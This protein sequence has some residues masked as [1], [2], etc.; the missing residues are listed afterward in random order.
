M[1]K[2]SKNTKDTEKIAKFF[3]KT[4]K[5][6]KR[7]ATL[8]G[9]YG[10]L[11]VGKT[12]FVQAVAKQLKLKKKVKS[13][14]FVIIKNYKLKTKNYKLLFHIDAYRLKDEKELAHLGWKEILTDPEH[15]VFIEW[16]EQV[17]KILP[18][19]HQKIFI[20]HLNVGNKSSKK[21][22]RKFEIKKA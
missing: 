8:I 20:S 5:P 22:H 12:T 9:L 17:I 4:L 10:D 18:K 1:Q 19:K 2:I 3:L 11:G 13:P 21:E 14:T 16:P 6:K 15:L 7:E